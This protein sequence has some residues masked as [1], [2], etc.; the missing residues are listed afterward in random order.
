MRVEPI[1]RIGSVDSAYYVSLVQRVYGV[2]RARGVG[3]ASAPAR[4]RTGIFLEPLKIEVRPEGQVFGKVF[5]RDY[6][7]HADDDSAGAQYGDLDQTLKFLVVWLEGQPHICSELRDKLSA[8]QRGQFECSD[9][10]TDRQR[11]LVYFDRNPSRDDAERI[12]LWEINELKTSLG[13]QD[14]L[15]PDIRNFLI[16]LLDALTSRF[17]IREWPVSYFAAWESMET[18]SLNST[19]IRTGKTGNNYFFDIDD[20]FKLSG[21]EMAV[22]QYLID[23]QEQYRDFLQ[24]MSAPPT[25]PGRIEPR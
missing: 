19:R 25:L 21:E 2:S 6:V 16:S 8:I 13:I 7:N 14:T 12:V 10:S 5:H 3:R 23:R 4:A 22:F 24:L 17:N 11:I 9:Q 18:F 1:G 15:K 20:A